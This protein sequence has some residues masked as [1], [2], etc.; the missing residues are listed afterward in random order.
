[1]SGVKNRNRCAAVLATGMSLLGAGAAFGQEQPDRMNKTLE[2]IRDAVFT[3]ID[4]PDGLPEQLSINVP[5]LGWVDATRAPVWAPGGMVALIGADGQRR[6]VEPP[7]ANTYR[8]ELRG[9]EG[10]RVR[11]SLY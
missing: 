1:M 11:L 6:L 4:V 8:G 2:T 7:T 3:P 9:H 5:G 10:S